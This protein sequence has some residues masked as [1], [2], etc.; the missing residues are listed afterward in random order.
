MLVA[1]ATFASVVPITFT[2]FNILAAVAAAKFAAVSFTEN[3]IEF[4]SAPITS[5][6]A[7]VAYVFAATV[8]AASITAASEPIPADILA[9]VSEMLN[10]ISRLFVASSITFACENVHESVALI[11]LASFNPPTFAIIFAALSDISY[12]TICDID[13]NVAP[14]AALAVP[15]VTVPAP[16]IA[17]TDVTTPAAKFAAVSL[18]LY[19]FEPLFVASSI[20]FAWANVTLFVITILIASFN[21]PVVEPGIFDC[22]SDIL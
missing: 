5:N 18:I 19:V 22:S 20:I 8:V 16:F 10:D 9:A 15:E 7:L 3:I 21:A 17:V 4:A 11:S 14:C 6:S 1:C 13:A 2:A 12:T